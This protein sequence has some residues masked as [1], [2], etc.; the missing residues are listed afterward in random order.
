M[1]GLFKNKTSQRSS[2]KIRQSLSR[3]IQP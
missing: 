2:R 3:L 1:C